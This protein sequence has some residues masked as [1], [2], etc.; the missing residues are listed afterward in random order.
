MSAAQKLSV[1]KVRK[2]S[3][4]NEFEAS[5]DQAPP[6]SFRA[7][8]SRI[9]YPQLGDYL[10]ITATLRD[11]ANHHI[12]TIRVVFTKEPV[13]NTPQRNSGVRIFYGDTAEVPPSE[14]STSE[15]ATALVFDPDNMSISGSIDARVEDGLANPKSHDL[16]MSFS[17]VAEP[18]FRRT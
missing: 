2:S 12:K 8:F 16:V 6:T 13:D 11:P 3:L 4:D 7:S 10:T 17:L 14:Y 9:N 18:G 5:I 15:T 1:N